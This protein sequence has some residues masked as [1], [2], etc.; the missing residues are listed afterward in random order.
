MVGVKRKQTLFGDTLVE[1]MFA[2]GIF[3]LVAISAISLMNRGLQNAQGALEITMARQEMDAQAESLRFIQ[4][5]YASERPTTDNVYTTVWEEIADNSYTNSELLNEIPDF[6][7][8]YNGNEHS[9]NEL[10]ERLPQKAFIINSRQLDAP[11]IQDAANGINGKSLADLIITRDTSSDTEINLRPSAT[12]PRLLFGATEDQADTSNLSD[13][14]ATSVSYD[15]KLYSAEGIWVTAVKSGDGLSCSSDSGG[16]RPDYYDFYI[17]TCWDTP[18][19]NS[20]T[21]LATTMRLQNPDGDANC[22]ANKERY[23]Y[24]VFFDRN[25]GLGTMSSA[26][27]YQGEPAPLPANRFYNTNGLVF[28]NWNTSADQSGDSYANQAVVVDLAPPRQSITLYAQWKEG[29]YDIDFSPNS[30]SGTMN[31]L[32]VRLGS[33]FRLPANSFTKSNYHFTSWNTAANKTGTTFSDKQEITR[34]LTNADSRITLYAQWSPDTYMVVFNPNGGTPNANRVQT[35]NRGVSTALL[36]NNY[37]RQGYTFR[38]WNTRADGSGTSYSDR[39][40]VTNLAARDQSIVLYAQWQQQ[41]YTV[42]FNGNGATSGSMPDQ[43]IARGATTALNAN[44]FSRTYFQFTGWNTAANGS[45]TSYSDRQ[46]VTNLAA[47]GAS[48]TLYAQWRAQYSSGA[49]QYLGVSSLMLLGK[50]PG[51]PTAEEFS[52]RAFSVGAYSPQKHYSSFTPGPDYVK[53]VNNW[54]DVKWRLPGFIIDPMDAY[55]KNSFAAP[56]SNA[57]H[58]YRPGNS[59]AD[60]TPPNNTRTVIY[61]GS[62]NWGDSSQSDHKIHLYYNQYNE[63]TAE[64]IESAETYFYNCGIAPSG[65]IYT[66]SYLEGCLERHVENIYYN[67]YDY[68][69]VDDVAPGYFL[70]IKARNATKESNQPLFWIVARTIFDRSARKFLIEPI[71]ILTRRLPSDFLWDP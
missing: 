46:N 25:G 10:Y 44:N 43:T 18:G 7:S 13:A 22:S 68:Y 61:V 5:A 66:W 9:C 34:D 53:T 8:G 41:A 48:I 4:E 51:L 62:Y 14:T 54:S 39:Q 60:F 17:R 24:T 35:I 67:E 1:V 11:D 20:S 69:S 58:I 64:R 12:Y 50:V 26:K 63:W 21:T 28:A 71:N 6:Y 36:A 31:S 32:H 70:N 40:Q 33:T 3:G 19:G 37:S 65:G 15:K 27:F 57:Y 29:Y 45:G 23:A 56:Q 52:T 59:R 42:K 47:A 16:F 55:G 30:G 2:V 38:G 49:N